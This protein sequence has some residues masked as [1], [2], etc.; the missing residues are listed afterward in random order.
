[1]SVWLCLPSARERGGTI[2]KWRESGYKLAV[3]RDTGTSAGVHADIIVEGLYPGYGAACNRLIRDA[4]S[5][6]P[7]CKWV[8]CAGDDTLPDPRHPDQIAFEC[9]RHFGELQDAFRE[10]T[11]MHCTYGPDLDGSNFVV[12]LT[13]SQTIVGRFP[14]S[15][16]GVMQPTGDRFARGSIERIAGSPWIGRDFC[17]RT[18]NGAGPYDP[19]YR[20]MFV[21]EALF[22]VANLLGCYWARP[23]LTHLHSHF[24]RASDDINSE[25]IYRAPPPHLV[26]ANSQAHWDK[27][28]RLFLQQKA[29]GFREALQLAP[30][31]ARMVDDEWDGAK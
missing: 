1:M 30:L 8:V 28:K 19:Q 4:F 29:G 3:W 14:W 16:F 24:M 6:D 22:D 13:P 31:D 15:T 7:D 12:A 26:E 23:D 25:A 17:L 2:A 20:H 21:D 11:T 18:Y 10:E 5:I 27:Y 9:G